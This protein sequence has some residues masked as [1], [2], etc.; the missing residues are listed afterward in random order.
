MPNK[1]PLLLIGGG[2]HCKTC[3]EVINSLRLYS[4][5]GIVDIHERLNQRVLGIEIIGTDAD[6]FELVKEYKNVLITM[7]QIKTSKLRQQL[8]ESL[9]MMGALLPTIISP[10]AVVS[11]SSIIAEG[12]IIMPKVYISAD[13]RIGFNSIINSGAIIEHDVQ[14]GNHCH[15][16]TA[17]VLNGEVILHDDIFIGSNS[18]LVQQVEIQSHIVIGAG[19]VVTKSLLEVGTYVGNPARR[20]H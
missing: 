13:V 11:H 4:I 5:V 6:L 12:T 15:I 18:V 3:I 19:S 10:D 14:V 1:E 20:I 8:Y 9:K 17:S 2:G 16:S 7:G